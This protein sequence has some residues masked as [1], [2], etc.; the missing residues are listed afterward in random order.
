MLLYTPFGSKESGKCPLR[1]VF[2]LD[3]VG[4]SKNHPLLVTEVPVICALIHRSEVREEL[5]ESFGAL[6]LA[7][8]VLDV[9]DIQPDI[10]TS[11]TDSWSHPL[12]WMILKVCLLRILFLDELCL[13]R[14]LL[15]AGWTVS[16]QLF[17]VER[18]LDSTVPELWSLEAIG[19]SPGKDD[20]VD[21]VLSS[22][23]KD[24]AFTGGRYVTGLPWKK[25]NKYRLLDNEKLARK[26]L[27]N[28]NHKL[29][30]NPDLKA[31]YDGVF[32][33][34][35]DSGVIEKVPLEE[36][37]CSRFKFCMPHRPLVC[38]DKLM[39][40]VRPVF[41]ASVK[42][43]NQVSLNDC[44]EV[45]PCLL[46]NL[47]EIVVCFRLWPVPVTA[48]IEKAF[49]Q[50]RILE[51][52]RDV[53]QVLWQPDDN[54]MTMPFGICCSPFL[55]NATIQHHLSFFHH[56]LLPMSYRTTCTQM[57]S[58]LEQIVRLRVVPWSEIPSV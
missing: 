29:S 42:A 24:V 46:L 15:L 34:M 44:M 45:G 22:F 11:T 33:Q 52:D 38:K 43:Y 56:P 37:E 8:G 49:H 6:G 55:L 20:L 31:C 54:V 25:G 53:H 41:D 14:S 30:G 5:L 10:L 57:I 39:M 36:K 13:S 35:L 32:Q 26:R 19:I 2:W 3:L 23:K 50:I 17:W 47:T 12:F 51:E 58:F 9:G 7:D 21:P 16:H 27:C 28:L 48:D 40:K 4:T 18:Q 1:N